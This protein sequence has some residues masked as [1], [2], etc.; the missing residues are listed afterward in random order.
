M[1]YL[2]CPEV[3][4][5]N[6]KLS[7]IEK[8]LIGRVIGLSNKYGYCTA[9]NQFFEDEFKLSS[10]TI[11]KYITKLVREGYLKRTLIYKEGTKEIAERR[12]VFVFDAVKDTP[13]PPNIGDTLPPKIG[14][15]TLDITLDVLSS[16]ED[17]AIA[18]DLGLSEP[19]I[20]EEKKSQKIGVLDRAINTAIIDEMKS[21]HS[22]VALP[23]SQGQQRIFANFIRKRYADALG[24]NYCKEEVI[25][26]LVETVEI[27]TKDK[28]LKPRIPDLQFFYYKMVL[29]SP[30][31]TKKQSKE[32]Y[33]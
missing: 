30:L 9:G 20:K 18:T 10:N 28:Y 8:N 33:L 15:D 13:L 16:E 24:Q 4:W 23:L 1:S 14:V 7:I 21:M 2:F 6:D 11:S 12:L 19:P 32:V 5:S 31:L 29:Y 17:N 26:A 27:M 3:V 25:K 22:L